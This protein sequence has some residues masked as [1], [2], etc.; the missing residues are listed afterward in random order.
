MNP[1]TPDERLDQEFAF[2]S[3]NRSCQDPLVTAEGD[4]RECQR[5]AGHADS[6]LDHADPRHCSGFKEWRI[7]WL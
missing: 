6:T 1:L 3:Y 7:W 5:I 2:I 4:L